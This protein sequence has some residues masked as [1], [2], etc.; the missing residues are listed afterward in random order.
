MHMP[1]AFGH[2]SD[3]LNWMGD[4]RVS[5][6]RLVNVADISGQDNPILLILLRAL[7][8]LKSVN[9]KLHFTTLIIMLSHWSYHV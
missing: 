6:N 1:E 5:E 9:A 7:P 2:M 4:E 3:K 8:Y